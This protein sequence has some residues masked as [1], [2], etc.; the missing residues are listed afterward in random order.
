MIPIDQEFVD[1]HIIFVDPLQTTHF[2][3]YNG[4]LGVFSHPIS[5][6]TS[7]GKFLKT[8]SLPITIKNSPEELFSAYVSFQFKAVK[9]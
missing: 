9:V 8:I 2:V 4:I 3:C 1:T 6:Q 5:D 7:V